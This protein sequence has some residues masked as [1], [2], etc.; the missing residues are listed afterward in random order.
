M[1]TSIRYFTVSTTLLKHTSSSNHL[2]IWQQRFRNLVLVNCRY[3][4]FNLQVCVKW[5]ELLCLDDMV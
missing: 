4:A 2:N 5:F 1:N 3:K